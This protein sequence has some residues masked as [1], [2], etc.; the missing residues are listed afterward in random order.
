[1][2]YLLIVFIGIIGVFYYNTVGWMFESWMY[3]DY[4]SHG[5]I[6]PIVSG[7]IVWKMRPVLASVE[8]KTSQGGLWLFI[9]GIVLQVI[10]M[11]WTIRFLSG[12]SFIVTLAGVIIYLFGGDFMKKIK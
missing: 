2:N 5:F 7:Y 3:N 10:S 9:A 1:M 4:Y 11:V 12:I 6:V 8:K